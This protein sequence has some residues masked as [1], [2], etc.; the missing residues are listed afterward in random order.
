MQ[1]IKKYLVLALCFFA[2]PL[3]AGIYL[4]KPDH[5]NLKAVVGC[6]YLHHE[7]KILLLHRQDASAEGNR[8]GIPGGKLPRG[9]NLID[10]VIRE[11]WEETGIE[12]D[13]EKLHPNGKLYITVKNFHFEYHMLDYQEPIADPG[14]I[15]INFSEHKGFTWVTPE[16]AVKMN[17]MTD[18]ATCFAITFGLNTD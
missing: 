8:W 5:F 6:C 1:Y 14:A 18:E 10:G 11:V 13:R 9:E 17:L 2:T 4:E 12:L 7:D 16:D 3:S 15:K